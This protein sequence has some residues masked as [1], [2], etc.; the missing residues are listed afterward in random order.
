MD[1][2]LINLTYVNEIYR[3]MFL[4]TSFLAFVIL[5]Y[6]A[7]K[8]NDRRGFVYPALIYF[9]VVFIFYTGRILRIPD[10]LLLANLFSNIVRTLGEFTIFFTSYLLLKDELK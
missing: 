5:F 6:K 8:N 3:Y 1:E 10:D 9:F 4:I 7:R 2:A